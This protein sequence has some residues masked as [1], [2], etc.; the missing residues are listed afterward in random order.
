MDFIEELTKE[1]IGE[2]NELFC[3][4]YNPFMVEWPTV[5]NFFEG[6]EDLKPHKDYTGMTVEFAYLHYIVDA[7][8]KD[9]PFIWD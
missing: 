7:V 3:Q 9:K 6:K 2:Y 5:V 8:K 4:S 1:K